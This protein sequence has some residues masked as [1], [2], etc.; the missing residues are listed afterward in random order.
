MRRASQNIQ[1]VPPT[2]DEHLKLVKKHQRHK[3]FIYIKPY[4]SVLHGRTIR[5]P[6]P[7]STTVHLQTRPEVELFFQKR[8]QSPENLEKSMSSMTARSFLPG[9]THVSS[10]WTQTCCQVS[11]GVASQQ[12][13]ENVAQTP[14]FMSRRKNLRNDFGPAIEIKKKTTK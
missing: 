2:V 13:C 12:K 14:D 3:I 9:P 7:H 8:I 11:P 1:Y 10:K 5:S 4:K 6:V